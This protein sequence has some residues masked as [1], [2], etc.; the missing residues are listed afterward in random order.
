MAPPALL[1]R[2]AAGL[3]L[4]VAVVAG[5]AAS[6]QVTARNARPNAS[7][8][9]ATVPDVTE[10]PPAT[11][12]PPGTDSPPPTDVPA[13]EVPS[14]EVPSSEV[15]STEAPASTDA[16]P[17]VADPD[18]IGDPLFPDLGN[19]GIDV[20]HYDLTLA[21]NP[22]NDVLHATV[23]LTIDF[24]ERRDAFTLDAASAVEVSRVTIDGSDAKFARHDNELAI[25][26][27]API[28]SGASSALFCSWS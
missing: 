16:P 4:V 7:D 14:T 5:C 17:V 18:G 10:L 25:T 23:A 27:D 1:V 22:A 20:E 3:A 2:R 11:A 28:G 6:S 9:G 26:P 24:T 8:P 13:T 15:P 19:P 21:Y 12:L